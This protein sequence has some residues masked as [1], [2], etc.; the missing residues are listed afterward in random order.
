MRDKNLPKKSTI[1]AETSED[2]RTRLLQNL[3]L[4]TIISFRLLINSFFELIWVLIAVILSFWV[5]TADW[6]AIFSS[7]VFALNSLLEIEFNE[8]KISFI[9][10]T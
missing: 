7:V 8:V 9:S 6:M 4:L 2:R 3:Y 1:K 5:L 10:S